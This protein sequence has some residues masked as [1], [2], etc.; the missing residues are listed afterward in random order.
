MDVIWANCPFQDID[1]VCRTNLPDDIPKTVSD[2]I[3]EDLLSI[4]GDPDDMELVV[5]DCVA[6]ASISC[7]SSIMLKPWTEVQ[8][9][10]LGLEHNKTAQ[11]GG[12]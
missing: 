6:S 3:L 9:V 11:M 12:F 2:V 10:P 5:I 8:S 1:F 7:H 4:L